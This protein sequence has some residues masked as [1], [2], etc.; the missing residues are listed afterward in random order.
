MR[1]TFK[2]DSNKNLLGKKRENKKLDLNESFTTSSTSTIE[3]N[4]M[5]EI[6][7]LLQQSQLDEKQRKKLYKFCKKIPKEI[8]EKENENG[9][10]NVVLDLDHTIIFSSL[11]PDKL[12]NRYIRDIFYRLLFKSEDLEIVRLPS[13]MVYVFR[14]REGLKYFF[15][16][17][18]KF[19]H[20][21]IYS[22][23]FKLYANQV[24]KK[25]EEKFEIKI[26]SIKAN[27][28]IQNRDV[29]KNLN[30]INL[31]VENSVIIDDNP[32]N[33]RNNLN[34]IILS[35]RFYDYKIMY[36]LRQNNIQELAFYYIIK[37]CE[38][39]INLLGFS[40]GGSHILNVKNIKNILPYN[41]ESN[42]LSERH[43]LN[44]IAKFIQKI[45]YLHFYYGIK[46]E[47][48][49]KILRI[50]IFYK[51]N[52]YIEKECTNYKE[53]YDMIKYCGGKVVETINNDENIIY[54]NQVFNEKNHVKS[55]SDEY[56]YDCYFM[57]NKFDINDNYYHY[58]NVIE[59]TDDD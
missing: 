37:E 16:N 48:A 15:D 22:S 25:L 5:D 45:Y 40:A 55:I 51:M 58:R 1:I 29:D 59:V 26:E 34:N 43:Q 50:N 53:L 46:V 31:N 54:I 3:D 2:K 39:D 13:N 47:D 32:S 11:F 36:F 38:K 17:T 6:N 7:P 52:F 23:S 12:N 9:K 8:K 42:N 41:V 49:I 19:C 28:D 35:K 18:K 57:K 30:K 24:V 10:I 33:W 44:F 21:H 20:Y 56:I 27:D 14:F 4:P